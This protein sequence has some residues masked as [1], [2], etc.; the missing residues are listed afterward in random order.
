MFRTNLKLIIR[1]LRREKLYAFV[2]ILG[3]TVGLTAFLLIALYVKDELSF[4]KFHEDK[5][6]IF[7]M[8]V[9]NNR[10]GYRSAVP[11][12]FIEYVAPKTAEIESYVRISKAEQPALV[13]YEAKSINVEKG[14]FV[15]KNFFEFFSFRLVNGTAQNVFNNP[16]EVV[17]TETLASKLFGPDNPLG[18]VVTL[19]KGE[20]FSVSAVVEDPPKNSTI[21]FDMLL[22]K[23]KDIFKTPEGLG[24]FRQLVT[25]V[26]LN[27]G[28]GNL[29]D[30]ESKITAFKTSTPYA[31][32]LENWN[33]ELL[34]LEDQRLRAPYEA[35]SSFVSND[36]QYVILFSGIGLVI[37]LL[38]LINYVNLV[39]AQSLSKMKE[40]GL[41]K[42]IG[43]AKG[44]LMAYQ[45]LESMVFTVVSF[46]LAFAIA[47]RVMPIFNGMLDK[48]ISVQY[49]SPQFFSWVILLGLLF[50]LLAGVYPAF[51]ISKYKPLTLL[52]KN[53]GKGKR[54]W[55]SKA[56]VLFQFAASAILIVVLFIINSQMSY[57]KSKELGFNSDWLVAVPLDTDSV[58]VFQT[59]KNEVSKISGVENSSLSGFKL[60]G[61]WSISIF[62]APKQGRDGD[63]HVAVATNACFADTDILNLLKVKY[64]WKSPELENGILKPNQIVINESLAKLM[65]LE[66]IPQPKRLYGW[67]DNEGL[68]LAGI[69]EDFHFMSLKSEIEPLAIQPMT[70]YGVSN[71]L[72]RI[73]ANDVQN[74]LAQVG[75]TF[76]TQFERPFEFQFIDDQVAD[77]YKKEQGQ[78]LLFKV[79]S[80][81]AL[82]ISML[83]LLAMTFYSV[84]QRRKEVSIRKV[85]G[86]S[87]KK[88][89]LMLNREYSVLV[90]IAFIVASPIAYYAMQGWLEEFKYRITISPMLFIGACLGFLLI[91]WLVTIG[92]SLKVSRENPA[93]V[94]RDE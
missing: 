35:D 43:A 80:G 30:L 25:Y 77:F 49:F 31:R 82:L 22:Y 24:G 10:T 83:G 91:S 28:L 67:S 44:Q 48:D 72:I 88:L 38:A 78:F 64:K 1:K 2:N 42:V 20:E 6:R 75:E 21:R 58:N 69:V 68:E 7:R 54:G 3:L 16:H 5:D 63:N 70:A 46:L 53:S 40:I 50:G 81:L 89:I 13:E 39:T 14:Y 66:E 52:A 62:D 4:D 18:K 71:L 32:Q 29:D 84:E 94:L 47:E 12:D 15:D 93:D 36:I 60:G 27:N 74:T 85:L 92:Q 37:L 34:P 33:F 51:Y 11:S 26:K 55:L 41:R 8:I 86:A 73:S 87:V 59:F 90:L 56:L 9:D 65:K 17:I 61:M 79:F 45:L 23:D 19:E 76:Q 57:L